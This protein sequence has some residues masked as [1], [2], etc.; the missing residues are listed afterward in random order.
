MLIPVASTAQSL[1]DALSSAYRNSPQ[2]KA[3]QA[4][5]RAT[6]EGVAGAV[7]TFRPTVSLSAT[8]AATYLDLTG[9][10]TLSASLSLSSTLTLWDGGSRELSLEVSRLA[11][12][13]GRETLID[14]EQTVLLNAVTA[15]MDMHLDRTYLEL[16]QNNRDVLE[17]QLKAANDRFEVGEIRR[18]DVSQTEAFLAGA[19]AT[20]ALRRGNLDITRETYFVATGTYPGKLQAPPNPPRLPAS[21]PAAIA[22]ANKNNPLLERARIA[23]QI[24]GVNVL[25]AQAAMKPKVTATGSVTGTSAATDG[26]TVSLGVTVPLYAG[27]AL[28]SAQRRALALDAK[29]KSDVQRVAMLVNQGVTQA[30]QYLE[31]ARASIVAQAKGVRASRVALNGIRE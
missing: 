23:S 8:G 21:L 20:V 6:D 13:A 26:A 18:T 15:F 12:S 16:A 2:L 17:Q 25:I 27:G 31:I 3:E 9:T 5:L 29:A 1:G 30:W 24:A 22:I 28:T 7:S 14:L 10:T 4:N 19:E 11:V